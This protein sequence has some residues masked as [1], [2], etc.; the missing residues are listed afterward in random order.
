MALFAFDGYG[1][2]V[3]F[4]EELRDPRRRMARVILSAFAI[5]VVLEVAAAAGVVAGAP[6]L[7]ALL[8]SDAP[9]SL[10][11][12]TRAGSAVAGALDFAVGLAILNAVIAT[13][14]VSARQL[15][16][17][18]RD[19]LWGAR[20]SRVFTEVEPRRGVPVASTI[21]AGLIAGVLCFVPLKLLLVLTGTGLTFV[22]GALAIALA[23][24]R[25]NGVTAHAPHRAWG[26]SGMAA[27]LL[28]ALAGVAAANAAD[29][30]TGR[31]S[32]IFTLALAA[33]SAVYY[34]AALRRRTG[35]T[36][37]APEDTEPG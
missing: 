22:Y 18:G 6:D 36:L 13:V 35:W 1:S 3:Y 15:Y 7:K 30:A 23:C 34:A 27:V 2:A 28:L 24:G 17:T 14:L 32:L 9:L 37:R 10:L 33:G 8:A 11:A 31:P 26:G 29:P 16:A 21:A 19:N 5:V 12:R 20:L 25:R 4:G